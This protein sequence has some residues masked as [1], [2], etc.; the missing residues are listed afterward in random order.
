M[1]WQ[2]EYTEEFELWW[3]GL[4]E[5]E[6]VEIDRKVHLLEAFGPTLPRPH[7]DVIAQSRHP[8]MKEWRGKVRERQI[9]VLFAFD[10]HRTAILLVGATRPAIPAGMTA[11]FLLP[12]SCS[13]NICANWSE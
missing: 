9:R 12:T 1:A 3:N 4:S 11:L 8:N 7:A 6:Q 5:E 2:V 13:I 10:S